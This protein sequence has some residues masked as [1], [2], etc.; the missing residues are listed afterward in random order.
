MAFASALRDAGADVEP[1][2]VPGVDHFEINE[3][4]GTVG[5]APHAA[6][7]RLVRRVAALPA[8]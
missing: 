3:A 8:G 4:I 2:Q 7:M 6:T 5:A 1:N